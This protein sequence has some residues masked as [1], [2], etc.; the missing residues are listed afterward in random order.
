M[1][2]AAPSSTRGSRGDTPY[3][4]EL[5]TRP[6]ASAASAPMAAPSAAMRTP[7]PTVNPST[8]PRCAPMA[9]RIPIS[10]VRCA[11]VYDNT[12]YN[13]T[14]ARTR[15]SPAN[16]PNMVV[17]SRQGRIDGATRSA[18]GV[19][20]A[21]GRSAAVPCIALRTDA[22]MSSGRPR[23]RTMSADDVARVLL[24]AD[25]GYVDQHRRVLDDL[26]APGV[27]YDAHH[28]PTALVAAQP[29]ALSERGLARPD[30]P[31]QRLVDDGHERAAISRGERAASY[32]RAHR[33]EVTGGHGLVIG[34]TSLER[35]DGVA[36]RHGDR[37][38][39]APPEGT[40]RCRS[41]VLHA[42]Q[43]LHAFQHLEVKRI[44]L[45][46]AVARRGEVHGGEDHVLRIEAEI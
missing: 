45:G 40:A 23:V 41:R 31:R 3:S 29:D 25:K 18:R 17:P 4:S 28:F 46:R 6:P 34:S 37:H 11:T 2:V 39:H 12:P 22:T 43:R 5:S 15:A 8:A 26:K 38:A 10:C 42:R 32:R 33:G 24:V 27:R 9:T 44:H 19:T 16:S 35:R 20:R 21:T 13:P 36:P 7:C 30:Q 14:A 1:V